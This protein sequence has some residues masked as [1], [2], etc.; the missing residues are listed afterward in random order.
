M[1]N[2]FPKGELAGCLTMHHWEDEFFCT[3][4]KIKWFN[5]TNGCI[6][7][8]K[9]FPTK[10]HMPKSELKRKGYG[11]EKLEKKTVCRDNKNSLSRQTSELSLSRQTPWMHYEKR[12]RGILFYFWIFFLK[13]NLFFFLPL[14]Y[15]LIF[16]IFLGIEKVKI[17][18]IFYNLHKIF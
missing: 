17:L 4:W 7:H 10:H 16:K 5:S 18:A 2:M 9:R 8:S 1:S 13:S 6:L 12:Q 14:T 3:I 15:F 11:P